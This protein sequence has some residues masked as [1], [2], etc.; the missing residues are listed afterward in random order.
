L[1]DLSND[2]TSAYAFALTYGN[3]DTDGS[4][5]SPTTSFVMTSTTSTDDKTKYN[6]KWYYIDSLILNKH[7]ESTNP[8]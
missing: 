7:Y 5:I 6:W 8:R 4:D 1:I 2:G 3:K